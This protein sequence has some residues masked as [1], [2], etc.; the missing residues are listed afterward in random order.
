MANFKTEFRK[1]QT[2]INRGLNMGPGLEALN[3]TLNGVQRGMMYAIAAAPKVGK[4]TLVN[5]GFVINTCLDAI[6]KQIPIEII[7]FSFEMDRIQME[8]DFCAHFLEQDFGISEIELLEEST[9]KGKKTIPISSQFL[10]GRLQDDQDNIIKV[11]EDL[12]TKVQTTYKNRIIPFFGEYNE[13]GNQILTGL[14]TFITNKENPT[15]L[16]NFLMRNAEQ[17]GSFIYEQYKK[18]GSEEI[19]NK[20]VS[21]LPT[22]PNR[23]CIVVTDTIR[24]LP[25]ERG[26]TIKENIDKW[27]EY[28]EEIR[29]LCGY[30][31]AHIIHLNRS[32]A[33]S[34][35][36]KLR[37]DTI[38]PTSDNIKDTGNV[39]EVADYVL[40]MFNPNDEKYNLDTH[41]GKKI[42]DKGKEP[43]YPKLRTIHIAES[44][45]CE[46]PQH[47]V[48]SMT[49][50]SKNF[51]KHNF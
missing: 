8:F 26:F 50:G 33:E 39:S 1:G 49:G 7:Y 25:R 21:Y 15:G 34:E 46:Y 6:K 45:H 19:F 11:T 38:Y 30:T 9:F 2:G 43:L 47:F 4:S 24:K 44:R 36:L 17:N 22:D 35:N 5:Y 3:K 31:F 14:I 20:L 16:R 28:T 29:N 10:R 37:K 32:L 51:T 27:L 13:N 23:Y 41:F 48:V 18:K 40:T 42:R 12:L